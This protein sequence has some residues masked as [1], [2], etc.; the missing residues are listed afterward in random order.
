MTTYAE[1]LDRKRV[2]FEPR[3]FDDVPALNSSLF[4]HQAAATE[5]SLRAGCSAMFLDTG[6]GKSR[7]ALEWARIVV[8]RTNKPVLMLAPLAV[9][10]QHVREA[11]AIDVDA[12]YIR[13]PHEITGPRTYITNYERVHKFEDLISDG[14]FDGVILDECFAP[15]TPIDVVIDGVRS[16]KCI[17]DVHIGDTIVNAVGLDVVSDV[18]RREIP[19]AVKVSYGGRSVISSPNHP[20]FT[21]RGWIAA[22]DIEPGD[23]IV[24]ASE[25]VRM[26]RQAVHGAVR[27]SREDA[28]LR[29]IL[30]SEM[31]DET[32]GASGEGAH[33]GG[34][35][36][37]RTQE[38]GVVRRRV[39]GGRGGA[40]SHRRPQPH[41]PAGIASKVIAPIE[42]DGARTFRA[43]GQWTGHDGA[44]VGFDGCLARSVGAGVG[45]VVGPADSRLSHTL[46]TRLGQRRS[47]SRYRGGW[48]LAPFAHPS[49]QEEGCEARGFRVDGIEVLELGHPELDQ[50][51][52]ADGKLYFYD[53]GGTRHP[54]F[55]I[56]GGLVHNS[57][58]LKS[59]TGATTRK[60]I[61]AFA[62]TPFRLA[63]TATPAPND[64]MELGQHAQFLGIMPS[65]EMLSR[66]FI[67]DQTE[68]GRYRLK[69]PAVRP[70]WDWVASW[71]RC[72]SLPSDLGFSD[73]GFVLPPLRTERH[74]VAV[75]R[76][77]DPGSDKH[78]QAFL[79][80]SP[81]TSATSIHK[82]K[83]RTADDRA[84]RVAEL[85][86]A[87]RG[88]RRVIWVDT[89]YEADA[90]TARIPEAVEVRGSM[91][92]ELKEERLDAFT[93][94]E[95][96]YLVTKP[97]IAGFG[98]NWQH[99]ARPTYA[100]AT[101][102]YESFYQSVRRFWRFGQPREVVAD[103]V[104]ADTESNQWAA[105]NRK[106]GDHEAMKSEM[107]SAMAR[108]TRTHRIFEDYRPTARVALPSWVKEVA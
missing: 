83:R 58:I 97:R 22:Q 3:G 85:T 62:R 48:S 78:G 49:G 104:M 96:S 89:D 46:Q 36:E 76:S 84:D 77:I 68:M 28:V 20:F 29:S 81:E 18:H 34:G 37:A 82:E 80:R 23:E 19:Y 7:A 74:I 101:Y 35:R 26:V 52:D 107:R 16:R 14:A 72:A 12:V 47:A 33:A 66:W 54:S 32:A 69:R 40:S 13:E 25:A 103:V 45:F 64:H 91:R 51:R 88:E 55:S 41:V 86:Y 31:A 87:E 71:A 60:L 9:G 11:A 106:A 79:F 1:L 94:G 102:S 59:F 30:L 75:D 73:D 21:R 5:F 38:G 65:N 67:T 95:I 44:A 8:E 90:I 100:G 10:P 27:P 70:F 42:S 56:Y 105:M 63:C 61:S 57:S 108:A 15:D 4:L 92:L 50:Y 2:S 43:W 99:C 6:L 24:A 53:L 98:L 17:E 93:R 39:S